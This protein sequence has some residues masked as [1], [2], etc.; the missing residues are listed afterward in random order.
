MK[1]NFI[2][3]LSL[4]CLSQIV[5]GVELTFDLPDSAKQCFFQDIKLNQKAVIEFQVNNFRS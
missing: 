4:I 1:S 5:Y 2:Y 3:G